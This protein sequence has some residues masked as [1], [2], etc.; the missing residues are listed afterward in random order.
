VSTSISKECDAL[1]RS[2]PES[3]S[4]G[5]DLRVS[6]TLDLRNPAVQ[7]LYQVLQRTQLS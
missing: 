5:G 3:P 1:T 2:C 6:G 4:G 7:R